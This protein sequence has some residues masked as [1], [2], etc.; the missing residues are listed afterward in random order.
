MGK[1]DKFWKNQISERNSA[2]DYFSVSKFH[3]KRLDLNNKKRFLA[4]SE[5]YHFKGEEG[6]KSLNFEK[7]RL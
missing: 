5:F 6:G 2:P 3:T 1:I 7:F 4:I